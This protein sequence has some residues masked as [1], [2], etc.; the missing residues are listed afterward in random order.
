M[1]MS[2]LQTGDLRLTRRGFGA[3][4]AA[5]LSATVADVDTAAAQGPPRRYGRIGQA[6]P[7]TRLPMLDGGTLSLE[8]FAGRTVILH[9]WGLWC[10]DSLNDIDDVAR[11]H[12]RLARSRDLAIASIHVREGYGQWGSLASFFAQKRYRFP[13]ALDPDSSAYRA[14][15]LRWTPSYVIIDRAG[16]I[17]DY[18]SGLRGD[19][20]IGVRG[21]LDRAGAVHRPARAR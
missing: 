3:G 13:V 1:D 15:G 8:A 10:A 9:V 4:A 6:A 16:V 2:R 21:L 11:L 17:R 5:C 14:W 7:S 20:G 12:R 18:A 19:G